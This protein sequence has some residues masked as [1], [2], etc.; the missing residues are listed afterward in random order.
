MVNGTF[1]NILGEGDD[2]FIVLNVSENSVLVEHCFKKS[3]PCWESKT[4]IKVVSVRDIKK[5]IQYF[6][7]QI[8]DINN[9]IELCKQYLNKEN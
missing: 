3:I 4:K 9:G 1:C 8:N 7:K 6:E 5:R 2:I